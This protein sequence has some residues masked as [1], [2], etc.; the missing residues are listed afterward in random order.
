ML[1]ALPDGG[2]VG[3]ACLIAILLL[4]AV[5]LA[6]DAPHVTDSSF[7][8]ASGERVLQESIVVEA[9]AAGVWKAF[10]D[11]ATIRKW[12]APMVRIDLRD[13]GTIDESEDPNAAPAGPQSLRQR[14]VA[15]LPARLLVMRNIA[16]PPS[17]P[18]ADTYPS[19]VQIVTLDPLSDSETLVSLSDTGFRAGGAYDTLYAFLRQHNAAYLASLKTLCETAGGC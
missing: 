11:E 16:A 14:I 12:N 9:P 10:T 7:S 18:G 17:M 5:A 13:G 1:L 19:I 2:G 15:F 8:E 4:P 3:L 6:E